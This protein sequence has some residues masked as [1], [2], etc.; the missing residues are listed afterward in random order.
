MAEQ[1]FKAPLPPEGTGFTPPSPPAAEPEPP[2]K[3]PEKLS[4]I[5]EKIV[6]Y[7]WYVLGGTFFVG[8]IFG[9]MM[10]SGGET[11][12]VTPTCKLQRLKNPDIQKNDIPLCGRTVKTEPCILYIMNTTPRDKLVKD[13]FEDPAHE[14]H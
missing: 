5:K 8:L 12:P 6:P 13:S 2:Q 11:A 4:D 9:M 14:R 10:T 7:L 1:I 3:A